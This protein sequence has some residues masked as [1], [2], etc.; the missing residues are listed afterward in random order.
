MKRKIWEKRGKPKEWK[1]EE[2]KE[3]NG[4]GK[5]EKKEEKEAKKG[6]FIVWVKRKMGRRR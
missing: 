3:G 6:K 1:K 4:R 5:D 2:Y